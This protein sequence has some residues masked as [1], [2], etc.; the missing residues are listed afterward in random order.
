MTTS[1]TMNAHEAIE[2]GIRLSGGQP[3]Q[4]EELEAARTS[5]NLLL[6]EWSTRGVNL[7]KLEPVTVTL[8]SSVAEV[9]LSPSIMD[10]VAMVIRSSTSSSSGPVIRDYISERIS[11]KDYLTYTYKTQS[12]RPTQYAVERLRDNPRISLWPVPND[13]SYLLNM[14]ALKKFEDVTTPAG[15]VDVPSKYLPS[16]S[17]GLG[18]YMA[19]ERSNGS[20]EWEAKLNRLR[21]EYERLWTMAYEEDQDRAS[22]KI[23]PAKR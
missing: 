14:W 21:L 1:F 5:L 4:F 3:T 2:K 22:M 7:W 19:M 11:Y 12:G 8:A 23:V 10:V 15:T 13:S 18:Y 20:P 9:S 17:Y 16:L 6:Q